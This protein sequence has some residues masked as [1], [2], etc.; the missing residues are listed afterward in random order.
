L[1]ELRGFLFNL[2]NKEDICLSFPDHHDFT[3]CILKKLKQETICVTTEKDYVRLVMPVEQLFYL[4]IQSSL[5]MKELN[6]IKLMIMW[7][8]AKAA[9]YKD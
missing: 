6:L 9:I 7:D 4:P 8:K 5:L 1:R 2:L 3:G